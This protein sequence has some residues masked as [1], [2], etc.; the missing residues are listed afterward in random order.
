MPT[1]NTSSREAK[2]QELLNT[3][4]VTLYVGQGV[5]E[6]LGS[7]G[8]TYTVTKDQCGC[9]D[10]TR[11]GVECKHRQAVKA[12]CDEYKVCKAAAQRGETIRPSTA[13]LQAVR[14]PEKPKATGCKEC[15]APTDFD[16][17]SGCFFGQVAA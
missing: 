7:R 10:F 13:L 14:W 4:A 1:K 6:V 17:C 8:I 11:R 2:A 12:L 16:I 15:G 5:A 9:P 3:G